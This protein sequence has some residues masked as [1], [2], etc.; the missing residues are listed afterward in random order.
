MGWDEKSAVMLPAGSRLK[1]P[2]KTVFIEVDGVT[3]SIKEWVEYLGITRA[4][5]N[6]AV[7]KFASRDDCIRHFI[8]LG[9]FNK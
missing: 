3:K 7:R 2:A 6:V 9:G 4:R 1:T 8:N 5:Y